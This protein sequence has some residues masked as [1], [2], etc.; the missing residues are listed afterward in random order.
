MQIHESLY[1]LKDQ[2]EQ[3]APFCSH[4]CPSLLGLV[5]IVLRHQKGNAQKL[6]KMIATETSTNPYIELVLAS[7]WRLQNEILQ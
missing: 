7:I 5:K 2:I 3:Y 4:S 6:I 1:P